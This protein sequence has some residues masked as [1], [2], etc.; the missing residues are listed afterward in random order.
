MGWGDW[1]RMAGAYGCTASGT[2]LSQARIDHAQALGISVVSWEDIQEHQFDFINAE[3]VFE[4]VTDPV[5]TLDYLCRSL[6]PHGLVQISVPNGWDI[7]R[8]LVV[9]DWTAP[10]GSANSLN[11]IAPLEHIN[12]FSHESLVRMAGII[13]LEPVPIHTTAVHKRLL[14]LSLRDVLRP[15]YRWV[16]RLRPSQHVRSTR[17][18]FQRRIH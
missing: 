2:E 14:D 5:G 4:H 8:R 13:G 10:K 17:V 6:K 1:C 9:M 7:K 11:P 18:F 3:Q 16:T 12:C 15:V